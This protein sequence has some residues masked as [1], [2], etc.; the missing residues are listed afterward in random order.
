MNTSFKAFGHTLILYPTFNGERLT[1][2]HQQNVWIQKHKQVCDE[3]ADIKFKLCL[4]QDLP[5]DAKVGEREL[6]G[7]IGGARGIEVINAKKGREINE[8]DLAH[9]EKQK[10]I[11]E[12]LLEGRAEPFEA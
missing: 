9:Y 3:I 7:S 4:W 10:E 12:A 8:V 6:S 5:D 1:R 2:I 11:L